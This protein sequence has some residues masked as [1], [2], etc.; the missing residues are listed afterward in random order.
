MIMIGNVKLGRHRQR[1]KEPMGLSP[2]EPYRELSHLEPDCG[3]A[4]PAAGLIRRDSVLPRCRVASA[5]K[6][7]LLPFWW[8]VERLR[9]LPLPVSS[10]DAAGLGWHLSW[11]AWSVGNEPFAVTPLEVAKDPVRH[12][13]HHRRTVEADLSFPLDVVP[14]DGCIVIMDGLHRLLK[15]A[16]LGRRSVHVRTV[17]ATDLPRISV[18]TPSEGPYLERLSTP[19]FGGRSGKHSAYCAGGRPMV[20]ASR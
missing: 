16:L 17:E 5:C 6:G 11:R 12:R 13:Y 7:L 2:L 15:A 20:A 19:S 9:A 18:P 4:Q 14:W 10:I 1:A 8:D 3:G